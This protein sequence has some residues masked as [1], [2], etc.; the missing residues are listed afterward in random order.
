M[1]GQQSAF[2]TKATT[3][4][5][6]GGSTRG[7]LSFSSQ[8][9]L[10]GANGPRF[11]ERISQ[12]LKHLATNMT[13]YKGC[14]PIIYNLSMFIR[15]LQMLGLYL[16]HSA[17]EY[18]EV[19]NASR[20]VV[21]IL[22]LPLHFSVYP[23]NEKYRIILMFLFSIYYIINTV[24]HIFIL[25]RDPTEKSISNRM[26][27]YLSFTTILISPNLAMFTACGYGYLLKCIIFFKYNDTL[28]I[29][30]VVFSTITL[31]LALVTHYFG[32]LILRNAAILNFKIMFRPWS[33]DLGHLLRFE[34]YYFIMAFASDFLDLN[35]QLM[36]LIY[37]ILALAAANPYFIYFTSTN[38]LFN[39]YQDV[40]YISTVLATGFVLII[41]MNLKY[42]FTQISST[43]LFVTFLIIYSIFTF[44]FKAITTWFM[45]KQLMKL[46]SVYRQSQPVLPPT[47]P[48]IFSG[49]KDTHIPLSQDAYNV[50]QGFS[51]LEISTAREFQT[52]VA[53]GAA[54][55]MPAV[56]NFDFIRW[57]LNFFVDNKSL[58]MCAQ[59][60]NYF[61]ENAQTQTVLLQY[62]TEQSDLSLPQSIAVH[63]LDRD[64]TD[65]ISDQPI[66]LKL[67]KVKA[68]AAHARCRRCISTFWSAVLKHNIVSMR[69]GI[70]KL[71]DA[72]NEATTHFDE[73]LRCYPYSIDAV[74]LYISFL[75]EVK[76]SFVECYN[77]INNTSSSFIEQQDELKANNKQQVVS[78][79]A[80]MKDTTKSYNEYLTDL[81][82]YS[83]QERRVKHNTNGPSRGVYALM[84]SAFLII[85]GCFSAIIIVTLIK[86][87]EYPGLLEIIS[88]GS[89]VLIEIASLTMAS[90]R[91]CLF[92]S[93]I[94]ND[95]TIEG[96]SNDFDTMENITKYIA[97]HAEKL[98]ALCA[99]FFTT[100]ARR[101]KMID[102]LNYQMPINIFDTTYNASLART[103]ELMIQCISNI[104]S[105]IPSFYINGTVNKT[106]YKP[107]CQSDELKTLLNNFRPLNDL[108]VNFIFVFENITTD[109]ITSL[110]KAFKW[111]MIV[112][113][114][115]FVVV[116][117]IFLLLVSICIHRESKFRMS[118]YLSLPENIASNIIYKQNN[119]ERNVIYRAGSQFASSS[120][121]SPPKA[122]NVIGAPTV[123]S[124]SQGQSGKEEKTKAAAIESLYQFTS[125][126]NV[127]STTGLIGFIAWMIVFMILGAIA[128][129]SLTYYGKTVNSSF[130]GRTSML[131][132]S[133][134]RFSTLQYASLAA[135]ESFNKN[136]DDLVLLNSSTIVNLTTYFTD[137]SEYL[138][139]ILTY[140][141]KDIPF[142]Y[143]EYPDIATLFDGNKSD[144][145]EFEDY[146]GKSYSSISHRGYSDLGLEARLQLLYMV[147]IGIVENFKNNATDLNTT[148]N[149][150][151]AYNHLL[152]TH[153]TED[154]KS[155]TGIYITGATN[156]IEKAFLAAL[157]I[158]VV[159]IIVLLL[160]FVIPILKYTLDLSGYFALTTQILSGIN[161]ETFRSTIYI[162]KWLQRSINRRNYRQ[163]EDSFKRSVTPKLQSEIAFE[164]PE[165]IFL[166]DAYGKFFNI[167]SFDI[168]TI[169]DGNVDI[170]S[171]LG[172]FFDL[173]KNQQ[174][175]DNVN[176]AFY[177]FQE[178]KDKAENFTFKALSKD[179]VPMQV[180]LKGIT[181]AD[182]LTYDLK[183]MQGFYAYV[184]V[185]IKEIIRESQD[186]EH[187]NIEKKTTLQMLEM[188]IPPHA[189]RRLHAGEE[190]I[191][192]FSGIGCVAVAEIVGFFDMDSVLTPDAIMEVVSDVKIGV[193][194]YLRKFP[195]VSTLGLRNGYGIFVA[196]QFTEDSDGM[197]EACDMLNF[198]FLAAKFL[199][200]G[201]QKKGVSLAFKV[202]IATG[203]PLYC[204]IVMESAPIAVTDG[205]IYII[206]EKLSSLAKPEQI[207][208]DKATV[209]CASS[210][211]M[212]P[213]SVGDVEIRDR[214]VQMW[215]IPIY[216]VEE[217]PQNQD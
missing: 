128:M 88:T 42:F 41:L 184:A 85:V 73:L 49:N 112:L 123:N 47:S 182:C 207:V 98:P 217:N 183:E 111:S 110:D 94:I 156:V 44:V 181:S 80:L 174:L 141:D 116:F 189:A 55:R 15:I 211:K 64:H 180:Y 136:N 17:N 77:F 138:H 163:F 179:G 34:Y 212:N 84:L 92:S 135:I 193:A 178:A 209:E 68:T 100:S 114:T 194:S 164:I 8:S 11:K 186:E 115:A 87:K 185:L 142:T 117:G 159:S 196:G 216:P 151:L 119:A 93:G 20:I 166:F 140:G 40:K 122:T 203:G 16:M 103:L 3:N 210:V 65:A 63:I 45:N 129:L 195:R 121:P 145:Q 18:W 78:I 191:C 215:S 146:V 105:N 199:E 62:L 5:A 13:R 107:T 74:S 118:L 19:Q 101:K 99:T 168:S 58:F 75:L 131:C 127:N 208:M 1:H 126:S 192:F 28:L 177:T 56:T 32:Y 53:I 200:E 96:V 89:D 6:A 165:K 4:S 59:V 61:H 124:S 104:A 173:S 54:S 71:R 152:L 155:T 154:L 147:T 214:K 201:A 197:N 143:R 70:C 91:L 169:D 150:W 10:E 161:P 125:M 120:G 97:T 106:C 35:K 171:I 202:G 60:C 36:I 206:A 162:N 190:S 198:I 148:S 188:V 82:S 37:S 79:S 52:I 176:R 175:L 22:T 38:A 134:S 139:D 172:L 69:D 14:G 133:A 108:S 57:G 50:M 39:N 72:I 33:S 66:F 76:S 46:Y 81:S 205:D 83:E 160:I 149:S 67:L 7:F 43:I 21:T 26:L 204:K 51:S 153:I 109:E 95:T 102:A 29:T 23:H 2:S 12:N 86:L 157:M 167:N 90:R 144:E 24:I 31:I 187:Y 113:P 170:K 9:V 25:L 158:S 27:F 213:V 130:V 132:Y 30:G 137:L 48:L